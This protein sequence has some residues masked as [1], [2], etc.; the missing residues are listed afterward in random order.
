MS[1]LL[2]RTS[3][4]VSY[5]SQTFQS[6]VDRKICLKKC[7]QILVVASIFIMKKNSLK[8]IHVL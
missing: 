6:S 8:N 7:T 3:Y 5:T 2:R 1:S 4:V